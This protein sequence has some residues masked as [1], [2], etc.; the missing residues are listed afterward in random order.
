MQERASEPNPA[1]RPGAVILDE[2]QRF[3][4]L[5]TSIDDALATSRSYG[6][7]WALAHQ[8]RDQLSPRLNAA[9]DA[10]ARN[11]AVFSTTPDDARAFARLSRRLEPDDFTT[12]DSYEA[13]GSLFV[14]GRPSEWF[15]FKTAPLPVLGYGD[16]L[17][18]ASQERFGGAVDDCT[19]AGQDEPP[20]S[21]GYRKARSK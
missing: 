16:E 12:L 1:S 19:L 9:L 6:V 15:T 18:R 20:S 8:F 7:S 5:P 11:R 2:L 3:L 13:Q 4:H 21:T 14:D 17:R 10:N